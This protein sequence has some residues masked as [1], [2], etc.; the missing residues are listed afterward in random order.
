[1]SEKK[2]RT[3]SFA[4]LALAVCVAVPTAQATTAVVGN[5]KGTSPYSTIAAGIASGATTVQVCPG[6]YPEQ[7]L[8]DRNLTLTGIANSSGG[9]AAVVVPPAGGLVAN[10]L[11]IFG[12]PVA[13]QILVFHQTAVTISNLVVDGTGNNLAGCGGPTLEGIYFEASYGKISDNVVRNQYQTDF[14]DYG[15]CQNGLAINVEAKVAT[16]V[17]ITGNSVRN[18]QKNGI[19][20]TGAATGPSAS[21]PVVTVTGNYIVGFGANPMNWPGGAGENGIQVGFGATGTISTNTVNDNIWFGEY[22][23]YNYDGQ[24]GPTTGNGASGILVYASSGVKITANNVGSAQYGIATVTDPTYGPGDNTTITSNK[25]VGIQVFDGIDVCSNSNTVES[26]TI[27]GSTESAVHVD[28]SCGSGNNNTVIKNIINEACAGVLLGTG[29]GTVSGPNTYY[30]VANNTLAGDVCPVVLAADAQRLSK[31]SS[32]RTSP[33][34][35][36]QN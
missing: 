23:Q 4:L 24:G 28:D 36:K 13:A 7:V 17:S 12:N 32:L 5:C 15:G 34:K 11:D 19:T 8:I 9:N 27:Y 18:Y 33:Y 3:L 21:G 35:P 14:T 20:A 31:H 30:G 25:V 2:L 6:T 26:N 16:T 29:S 1:M 22:S 10:G